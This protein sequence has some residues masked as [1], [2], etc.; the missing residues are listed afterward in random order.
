MKK[1]TDENK[2]S[3]EVNWDEIKT[4]HGTPVEVGCYKEVFADFF[5]KETSYHRF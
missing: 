4:T 2:E 1:R 5:V 3:A